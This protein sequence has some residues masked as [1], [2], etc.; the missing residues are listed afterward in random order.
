MSEQDL[1]TEDKVWMQVKSV[2][3][4]D[5]LTE[6]L[7]PNQVMFA[8]FINGKHTSLYGQWWE[9][10]HNKDFNRFNDETALFLHSVDPALAADIGCDENGHES[11]CFVVV[12][13]SADGQTLSLKARNSHEHPTGIDPRPNLHY[14]PGIKRSDLLGWIENA[15]NEPV[16]ERPPDEY[17]VHPEG[18][19]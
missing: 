7:G 14:H 1:D 13:A 11:F 8:G 10:A 3:H 5:S 12:K 6:K 17:I 18:E 2:E 15:A 4:W 19:E 16:S 9:L